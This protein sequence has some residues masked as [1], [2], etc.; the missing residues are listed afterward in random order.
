MEKVVEN[1]AESDR[2]RPVTVPEIAGRKAKGP[3]IV[4]VTA[5]DYPTAIIV[6]RAGMDIVLVGDSLA[7]VMLGHKGTVS[8]GMDE[9]IHHTRAVRRGIERALLVGDMPFLSYQVSEEDAIRNAGRFVKEAGVEAVKLEGGRLMASR[10]RAIVDAGIPVMGHIGLTPQTVGKLGG[11]RVQGRDAAGAQDLLRD[12]AALESAGAFA[13]ILECVPDRVAG[14]ITDSISIPTIGIGAGPACHGQVLV[15]HDL[16]GL[17]H[18][19]TA[20][21]VKRYADIAKEMTRALEV[22]RDEVVAGS[23]PGPEH[24]FKIHDREFQKIPPPA[25]PV[26]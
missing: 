2:P 11:Y 9:M 24:S 21:F 1:A 5:Y 19:R 6:D 7:N 14:R 10:V 20:R 4:M 26:K 18:G 16:L 8:V 25:R 12:A 17:T 13:L 3:R 15:L 23:F 22:Y